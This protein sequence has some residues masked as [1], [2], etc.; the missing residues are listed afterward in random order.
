MTLKLMNAPPFTFL[1]IMQMNI[2][3]Y[4]IAGATRYGSISIT[5][6]FETKENF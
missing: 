5:K 2:I 3:T 1:I 4:R 6:T